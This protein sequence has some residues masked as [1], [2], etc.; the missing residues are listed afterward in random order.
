MRYQTMWRC[1]RP[2]IAGYNCFG[3]VFA[4]RRTAIYDIEYI[5]QI[6]CEDGYGQIF[7]E[8]EFAAGDIVVYSDHDGP[9]HVARIVRFDENP[10]ATNIDEPLRIPIVLSKFDDVSGEYEHRLGDYRW[11]HAAVEYKVYRERHQEPRGKPD[12][13]ARI[14]EIEHP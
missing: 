9:S 8:T 11:A 3:H 13:K 14:T 1:L 10:I 5:D 12:W 2:P 4:S 6:L 7:E